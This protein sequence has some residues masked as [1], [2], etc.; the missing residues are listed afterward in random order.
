[1]VGGESFTLGGETGMG[2]QEENIF[3]T[4]THVLQFVNKGSS[5]IPCM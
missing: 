3:F 1:M 4:L 5:Y 2:Y